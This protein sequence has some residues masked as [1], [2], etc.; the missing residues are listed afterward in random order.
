MSKKNYI[1]APLT[2]QNQLEL[3]KSRGLI[4]EDE[5][6]A[7]CYLQG[8]S[9]YRLSAYFL[10]YQLVKDTFNE[11]T[12]FKQIIDTYSFDRELRLLI[13]DCIER[14]EIAIRTQFIYSLAV[15]YNDSHWQD[16]RNLFSAPFSPKPGITIDPF[17]DLQKIID[18]AKN[19]KNTE[20]FIKH[21]CDTYDN[22]PNPPSWMC[23]ELLT[24]GELSHIFRGLKDKQDRNRI[25]NFFGVQQKVFISWLHA[26]TYVRNICAHHSRLWNKDLAIEPAILSSPIGKWITRPFEIN[27]RT[28]YFLCVLK[29]LLLRANAGN[30]LKEKLEALFNKY[31]HIPIQFMGIPSD[32]N[33]NILDWK[34]EPLWQ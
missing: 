14:V 21:Y 29:Y 25:A 33:G 7:I 13:F 12:T 19:A 27:Q 34:N 8:I 23:L 15:H 2:F 26:I 24:M 6:K 3:L 9:Y 32:G 5:Q 1:K 17:T 10:P 11:G 31:P 30:R 28:F 18:K 22:P 4:V 20:V 16:N